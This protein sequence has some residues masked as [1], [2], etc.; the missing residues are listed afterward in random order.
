MV[1]KADNSEIV[2][3]DPSTTTSEEVDGLIVKSIAYTYTVNETEKVAILHLEA[4][5]FPNLVGTDQKRAIT[6]LTADEL[7]YNNFA[8]M[9]GVQIHQVW[10]RAE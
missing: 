10:K 9:S 2:S 4:S 8:A 6:S 1:A 3:N 7:T 5:T